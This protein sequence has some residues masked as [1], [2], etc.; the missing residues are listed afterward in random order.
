MLYKKQ[1]E[2]EQRSYSKKLNSG[3]SVAEGYSF[4]SGLLKKIGNSPT[5]L[6]LPT[7]V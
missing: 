2:P 3:R 1:V 4:A 5:T 6:P 7:V